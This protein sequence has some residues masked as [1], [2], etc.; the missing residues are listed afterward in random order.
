[1][2]SIGEARIEF[3]WSDHYGSYA[4]A[5]DSGGL[6]TI[7]HDYMD[8]KLSFKSG[9]V[10]DI[11]EYVRMGATMVQGNAK[12]EFFLFDYNGKLIDA[13]GL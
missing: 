12:I 6:R 2:A 3:Y 13:I 11:V 8:D 5:K 9:I 1:M 7:T 4:E 10:S